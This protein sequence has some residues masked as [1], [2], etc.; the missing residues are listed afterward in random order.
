MSGIFDFYPFERRT[1]SLALWISTYLGQVT[2]LEDAEVWSEIEAQ[3]ENVF[4]NFKTNRHP[5]AVKFTPIF[6]AISH[7][8][9]NAKFVEGKVAQQ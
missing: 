8:I 9:E 4:V 6:A 7:Q 2:Q 1:G 3:N 5:S